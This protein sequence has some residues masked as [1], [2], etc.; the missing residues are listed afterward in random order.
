MKSTGCDELD[1]ERDDASG[2]TV[3]SRAEEGDDLEAE[4]VKVCMRGRERLAI[5][6]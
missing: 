4:E 6:G 5:E 3:A 2:M 1:E